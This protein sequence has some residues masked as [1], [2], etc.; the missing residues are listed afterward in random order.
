MESFTRLLIRMALMVRRRPSRQRVYVIV[1]VFIVVLVLV[2]AEHFGILPEWVRSERSPG[3]P[4]A[5]W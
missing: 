3:Y 1:I 5:T 4:K 2:S